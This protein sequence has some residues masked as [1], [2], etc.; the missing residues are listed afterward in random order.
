MN[1]VEDEIETLGKPQEEV[2]GK[3]REA[4]LNS[5]KREEARIQSCP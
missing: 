5:S 4:I 3:K 2:C 1:I